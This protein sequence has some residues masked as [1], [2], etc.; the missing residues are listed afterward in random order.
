MVP[1]FFACQT[2]PLFAIIRTV[3]WLSV[4]CLAAHIITRFNIHKIYSDHRMHSCVNLMIVSALVAVR[5]SYAGKRKPPVWL[6]VTRSSTAACTRSVARLLW[7]WRETTSVW[8][9]RLYSR[10]GWLQP[11]RESSM[12]KID[13]VHQ[14]RS[15]GG[16]ALDRLDGTRN[17]EK[18]DAG[19][20]L[21]SLD[22]FGFRSID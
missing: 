20:Q 21:R 15:L 3:Q 17:K 8:S 19:H 11:R 14:L 5:S 10:A 9:G 2:L 16:S 7:S 6:L 12:T 13:V 18:I 4:S 1:T 22:W